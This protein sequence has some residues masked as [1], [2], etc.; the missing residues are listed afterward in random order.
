[1]ES[2]VHAELTNERRKLTCTRCKRKNLKGEIVFIEHDEWF[3]TTEEHALEVVEKWRNWIIEWRPYR[4]DGV[5]HYV[6]KWKHGQEKAR[7][8]DGD[9]DWRK[10]HLLDSL[11]I[12]WYFFHCI[13]TSLGLVTLL[14]WAVP[15][16]VVV[17]LAT[18]LPFVGLRGLLMGSLTASVPL[19]FYTILR[20]L[21]L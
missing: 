4:W 9:V 8:E 16:Y 7:A 19:L 17:V 15:S 10:W 1:V 12:M 14:L 5:L 6:W 3:Q 21:Y 18:M 11:E 13:H 20:F 2:L